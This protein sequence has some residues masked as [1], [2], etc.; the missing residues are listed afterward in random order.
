MRTN[1]GGSWS[2]ISFRLFNTEICPQKRAVGLEKSPFCNPRC[3]TIVRKDSDPV[4][5][6]FLSYDCE[7][8]FYIYQ[9]SFVRETE[10]DTY[11]IDFCQDQD[12][13]SFL[14]TMPDT[15]SVGP[16]GLILLDRISL[17]E[18]KK[19]KIHLPENVAPI[20]GELDFIHRYRKSSEDLWETT[21]SKIK[22][23]ENQTLLEIKAGSLK[24]G[25]YRLSILNSDARIED[26]ASFSIST[27]SG[28]SLGI[29][30]VLLLLLLIL[31]V[32]FYSYYSYQKVKKSS[33]VNPNRLMESGRIKPR[34]IFV[35]TNVDNRHHVDIVLE[36]NKYLKV[37]ESRDHF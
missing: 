9:G 25:F 11:Q 14:F 2:R 35:I 16:S 4:P 36:F 12:C 34:S 3:V 31:V 28:L 24:D 30:L 23:A 6:T 15:R 8:G 5:N 13:G 27:D 33:S 22:V 37:R 26:I 1:Y 20:N 10:G 19:I 7:V 17:D 21:E 18:E 32:G 29:V